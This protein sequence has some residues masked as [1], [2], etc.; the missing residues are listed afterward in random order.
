MAETGARSEADG[1]STT[2]TVAS[3]DVKGLTFGYKGTDNPVLKNVSLHL[4][5]GSRCLLVGANGAGKTTM[6]RLLAGKC[7]HPRNTVHVMG[8]PAFYC[9][10]S[11]LTY[12]GSEWRQA[13]EFAK[14][15]VT[16][17][18]MLA[19]DKRHND[20]YAKRRQLLMDLLEVQLTW[21]TN[22]LSDGQL[23]RVQ[24]MIGLLEPFDL[25]LMDEVT[26]DLDCVMRTELLEFLKRDCAERGATIVYA[27]HIFDG[28]D[29]WPSHI[30]R[31][32][33]GSLSMVEPSSIKPFPCT[34]VSPLF[35]TVVQWIREDLGKDANRITELRKRYGL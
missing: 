3:V 6:L 16:V 32:S 9:T 7:M 20:G 30:A 2:S 31:L 25:L 19:A 17:S 4:P 18:E 15:G 33:K 28:L 22:E 5:R 29:D 13:V 35:L 11:N 1:T 27:T 26:V 21:C 34:N 10:P 12:L 14:V 8:Q 24:I 23:R